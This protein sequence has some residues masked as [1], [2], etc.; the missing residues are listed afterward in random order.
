AAHDRGPKPLLPDP[1]AAGPTLAFSPPAPPADRVGERLPR[2]VA[3]GFARIKVGDD[4]V[5]LSPLPELDLA[6]RETI[7][8]V[9]DRLVLRAD[10]QTRLAGSLEQAFQEGGGRA[11]VEILRDGGAPEV[12]RYGAQFGCQ[13]SRTQ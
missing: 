8:V 1:P 13:T 5:P 2:L 7:D 11:V 9:L 12:R 10:A 3:R 6:G 4:V